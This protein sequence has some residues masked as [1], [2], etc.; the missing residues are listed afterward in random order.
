MSTW[1]PPWSAQAV[2]GDAT[3]AHPSKQLSRVQATSPSPDRRPRCARA[4]GD[5]CTPDLPADLDWPG[6]AQPGPAADDA[7]APEARALRATPS[8]PSPNRIDQHHK[9]KDPAGVTRPDATTA[10]PTGGVWRSREEFACLGGEQ[11][12]HGCAM[13]NGRCAP[14]APD[15]WCAPSAN[16]NLRR[17]RLHRSALPGYNP[18]RRCAIHQ[19][20]DQQ[21]TTRTRRRR[22][23][24]CRGPMV[25]STRWP[26]QCG[27]PCRR[28][29][30]PT[31]HGGTPLL[32]LPAT[33][34]TAVLRS[35]NRAVCQVYLDSNPADTTHRGLVRPCRGDHPVDH[36]D[37]STGS[38]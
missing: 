36:P 15:R 31:P 26:L 11:P 19:G 16:P 35:A 21:E 27:H 12:E 24:S 10:T 28:G 14:P 8:Q 13:R 2:R 9:K 37:D 34:R 18:A 23:L 29:R 33:G 32:M 6:V 7:S 25:S 22:P 30:R 5:H 1:R 4:R 3:V 17:G 38:F 20:W